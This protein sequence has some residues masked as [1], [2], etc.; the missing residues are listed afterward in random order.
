MKKVALLFAMLITSFA[1]I[2]SFAQGR[3]MTRSAEITF[4]SK[5]PLEDIEATNKAAISVIE[6]TTGQVEFSV[7]M[8]GFTFEKALMQEHFNENYVESDDFPKAT[9]KGTIANISKVNFSKDGRYP[10][11]INGSLTL[12]GVTKDVKSEGVITVQK[13]VIEGSSELTIVLEDYNIKIPALVK[14]KISKTVRIAIKAP[15]SNL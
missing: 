11:S 6:K 2:N 10:I 15:Y 7:L 5:A 4:Y 14:D 12:H 3:I 8:K 9:F 13:G 1:G